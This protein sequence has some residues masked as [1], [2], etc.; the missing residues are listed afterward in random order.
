MSLSLALNTALT[1][2][3]VNQ[4]TMA[5]ISNNIANANTEGYSRQI[6]NLES[7]TY[8]G[9]GAGVRIEDVTRTVDQYLQVSIYNQTSQLGQSDTI[10]DY[11][12]QVQ[13]LLGDPSL[14][15]SIDNHIETFFNDIQLMAETPE[16]SST[17]AAVIQS[18]TT[19]ARE[20]AILAQGLEELRFQVDSELNNSITILNQRL[21]EL[22]FTNEA[23]AEAKAFGSPTATLLDQR[24]LL[25]EEIAEYID[26]R[27]NEKENG[28]VDLYA[29]NGLNL[30][31]FGYSRIEYREIGSIDTLIEEGNINPLILQ[32]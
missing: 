28:G 5:L 18:A 21:E 20:I 26:I 2:L 32:G 27:V 31:D 30:I 24:D 13:I 11:Y 15:N 10:T 7:V 29:G 9:R 22:F 23:I 17:R 6:V 4:R 1:G 19:A 12:D 8:D 3:K 25:I 16:R 14:G